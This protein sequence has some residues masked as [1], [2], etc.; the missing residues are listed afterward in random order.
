MNLDYLQCPD[1]EPDL[2]ALLKHVNGD[3]LSAALRALLGTS[4]CLTDSRGIAIFGGQE[5]RPDRHRVPLIVQLEPIGYLE[6]DDEALL[7]HVAVLVQEA[8]KSAL[9]YHLAATC[10][11]EVVHNDYEALQSEHRALQESEARYRQLAASLEQRVQEQV[12]TIENAQRQL[13]QA[14]KLASVG[15]LAAG[16]AHEINNPI[17]FIPVSYTHLTLPTNSRV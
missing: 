16:I 7:H 15:Q 4:M 11:A 9:R 10:H 1:A 14:E 12:K 3:R 8:L 2:H 5:G 13:Y 17:G 6:G